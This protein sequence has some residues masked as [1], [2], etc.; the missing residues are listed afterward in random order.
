M[1]FPSTP[2]DVT[3]EIYLGTWID[4]T[5]YVYLR[6][7]MNITRG[8]ADEA[9][10]ADPAKLTLTLNN[11]DGR[12]SPRNPTGPYYGLLGRNTP[13]R[14]SV[15]HSAVT[16]VRYLGEVAV[17]P[18]RWDVSGRDVW[19]PIEA[20]DITRRLGAGGTLRS[21]MFRTMTGVSPDDYVPLQY[22]PLEDGS[23]A[24]QA[25]SGL[26]G[27]PAMTLTG[28]ATFAT[29]DGVVGSEPLLTLAAGASLSVAIPG[30]VA[31]NGFAS[32]F[33]LK[34]PQEPASETFFAQFTTTGSARTIK[35]GITPG[36]PSRYFV[37]TYDSAGTLIAEYWAPLDGSGP[38]TPTEANFFAQWAMWSVGVNDDFGSPEAFIGL[39]IGTEGPGSYGGAGAGSTL[40]TV[41]SARLFGGLN[42]ASFG[43]LGVFTDAAYNFLTDAE[44][45]WQAFLGHAGEQAHERFERICREEDIPSVVVGT[46]SA[47]MGPQPIGKLLDIFDDCAKADSGLVYTPADQ[48]AV[49][50]R[51]NE[52]RYNQTSLLD[53]DYETDG[54]IAPPLEPIEDDLDVTNDLTITRT[55]GSSARYELTEGRNQVADPPDGIGRYAK[56]DTVNLYDDTQPAHLA[57]WTVHVAAWDE[58]R[59]PTVHVNLAAAPALIP[60][61]TDLDVADRFTIDNLPAW[62]PPDLV[63]LQALGYTETIGSFDWD[64]VLNSVP[65]G[66][67]NVFVVE[68]QELGR[69]D[70]AGTILQ[71]AE[72]SSATSMRFATHAGPLWITSAARPGDFPLDV[73]AAGEQV[74]VTAMG[75]VTAPTFVAAGTSSTGSSGS[76]TPGLPAGAAAGDLVLIWA[77]TRNS[78]TGTVD[79]PAGWTALAVS[80]NTALLGRVYDGSWSMPTVT[81]SGGAANEDTIAQ[82]C[83]LR[84]MCP[85]LDLIVKNS[86]AQLNS[87]AQDVGLPNLTVRQDRCVVLY[88]CWKQDDMT[89]ATS[90]PSGFTEIQ[91]ATSAAG[92]DASQ[93]WGY[94]IQTTQADIIA[95]TSPIS[96]TITGGASAISRGLMVALVGGYQT[97]TVTRSINSV[98]KAQSAGEP[99]S[100]WRP[101]ALAL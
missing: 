42:G 69:L 89:A 3:V 95:G 71:K 1:A 36:S 51:T 59:Y 50:F 81:F 37:R 75:S 18:P 44:T 99:I 16:Y 72:T 57:A 52:S 41:T 17:W 49:A 47:A 23:S 68:D 9:V 32:Q 67:F 26:P 4:V 8:L 65:A 77:S 40:G 80:G 84:G 7:R 30:H 94:S 46:S 34:V 74:R 35:M 79:T 87:S 91:E 15:T 97:A 5:A 85:D 20:A 56:T 6:D 25:A 38:N 45:T 82:S 100:L 48:L 88:L 11:R 21:A 19:V 98:V 28:S 101:A 96:I 2:L 58:A 10:R 55:G 12:F 43:H 22:W 78:G 53:L 54:H 39:G 83:A 66:P 14:V 90:A 64:L 13:I 63:D 31:T 29:D 33:L 60:D 61:V 93:V 27:G 76:R 24:T 86:Q 70:T 62:L 73:G 92:N